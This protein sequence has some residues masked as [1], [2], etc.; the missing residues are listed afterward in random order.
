MTLTPKQAIAEQQKQAEKDL[1]RKS[2]RSR[3]PL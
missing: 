1:M 3:S 2:Q